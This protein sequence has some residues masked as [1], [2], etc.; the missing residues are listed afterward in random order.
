MAGLLD[1]MGQMLLDDPAVKQRR[2]QEMGQAGPG[3]MDQLLQQQQAPQVQSIVEGDQPPMDMGDFGGMDPRVIGAMEGLGRGGGEN[4]PKG[5]F[6]IK[7]DARDILGTI[8]DTLLMAYRGA[9]PAFG[10][11]KRK[12]KIGAIYSKFN[13]DPEGAIRDAAAAGDLDTAKELYK[14]YTEGKQQVIDNQMEKRKEAYKYVNGEYELG[15]RYIPAMNKGNYQAMKALVEKR[16]QDNGMPMPFTL[17]PEFDAAALADIE[18]GAI[19]AKDARQLEINQANADSQIGRRTF[20]NANDAIRTEATTADTLSKVVDREHNQGYRD[21][22]LELG[23]RRATTG[24]K[25]AETSKANSGR[26]GGRKPKEGGGKAGAK[27]GDVF[28][29]NKSGKP[30]TLPNGEIVPVGKNAVMGKDGE[31]HLQK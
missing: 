8:G 17:P 6:G 18:T 27:P 30:I 29:N 21:G 12:E 16:F 14:N 22:Q 2:D 24:E 31:L 5:M 28:P 11:Q 7:G 20:Q 13:K 3:M 23:G 9:E 19:D 4:V 25:N 1:Y 26:G 10:N 15:A